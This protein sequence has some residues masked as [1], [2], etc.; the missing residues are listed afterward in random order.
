VCTLSSPLLSLGATFSGFKVFR[1]CIEFS[2]DFSALL[3]SQVISEDILSLV[4]L[5]I[6]LLVWRFGGGRGGRG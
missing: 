3:C 5:E 1:V 4:W 2:V 6:E